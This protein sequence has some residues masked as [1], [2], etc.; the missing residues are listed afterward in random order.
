MPKRAVRLRQYVD[1]VVKT[2]KPELLLTR[3][4]WKTVDGLCKLL[5]PFQEAVTH[6]QGD[7]YA[8]YVDKLPK[9]ARDVSDTGWR[10]TSGAQ[11]C[12]APGDRDYGGEELAERVYGR[13][14]GRARSSRTSSAWVPTPFF[15]TAWLRR[16]N[17][18]REPRSSKKRRN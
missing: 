1:E 10:N 8:T 11:R 9:V 15:A 5:K 17:R 3:T 7:Q 14:S 18:E 16:C 13:T 2:F 4:E 6:L 12:Q